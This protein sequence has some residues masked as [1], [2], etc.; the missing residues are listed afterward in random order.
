MT[1]QNAPKATLTIE[2]ADLER[3]DTQA[4]IHAHWQAMAAASPG[5]SMHGLDLEALKAP[6]IRAWSA[7]I[8]G[9]LAG[10]GALYDLGAAHGELKS[11]RTAEPFARRGVASALL[12]HILIAA[13]ASGLT[14]LSLETGCGPAFAPALAFYR[15]Q[16]FVECPP[17]GD[18]TADP[19]SIFLTRD[20]GSSPADS[21]PDN[22]AL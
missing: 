22:R 7:R 10:F 16:G 6:D 2:S 1:D 3:P 21:L 17:F 15:S 14:R 4:L 13:R 9:Q 5:E 11:M 12:G 8:D 19:A 18:Y 20:L